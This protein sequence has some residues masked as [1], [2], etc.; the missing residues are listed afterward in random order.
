MKKINHATLKNYFGLTLISS[1]GIFGWE[2][3]QTEFL[4]SYITDYHTLSGELHNITLADGSQVYMDTHTAFNVEYTPKMRKLNLVSGEIYIETATEIAGLQRSFVV[5]CS[6]GRVHALGTRF[7]VK[8][9]QDHCQVAVFEDAVEIKSGKLGSAKSILQAGQTATFTEDRIDSPHTT[10][11]ERPAWSQGIFLAENLPLSEF[12]LQLNRYR[13]DF[14]SCDPQIANLR[15]VGSFPLNDTDRIL[16]T[17]Q[18]TLPVKVW[19]PLP[20]WIK[21]SAR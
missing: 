9:E 19:S 2:F 15:I 5:E 10:R 11:L 12:L 18:E 1:I 17:L 21:V 3:W 7:S 8:Q 13:H 14:L 16:A 20:L 6:A 4:Q